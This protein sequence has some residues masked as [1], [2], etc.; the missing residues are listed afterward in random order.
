MRKVELTGTVGVEGVC[1]SHWELLGGGFGHRGE[2]AD[3]AWQRAGPAGPPLL[4]WIG[5]LMRHW[6]HTTKKVKG[7]SV[8]CLNIPVSSLGYGEILFF[9]FFTFCILRGLLQWVSIQQGMLHGAVLVL[10]SA[11]HL[12]IS[13]QNAGGV[14]A[15]FSTWAPTHVASCA[16]VL[17]YNVCFYKRIK[18]IWTQMRR[19]MTQ[20]VNRE[21]CSAAGMAKITAELLF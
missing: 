4:D 8:L 2:G 12:K 7:W 10:L 17:D 11:L 16:A 14:K 19:K 15:I 5:C 3:T 20:W 1:A 18:V 21:G 13:H 6:P 9:N